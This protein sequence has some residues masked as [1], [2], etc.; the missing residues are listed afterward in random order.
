VHQPEQQAVCLRQ[1]KQAYIADLSEGTYRELLEA[2]EVC[3]VAFIH[4]GKPGDSNEPG[5]S[6]L[7]L[8][9]GEFN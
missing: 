4:P 6:D 9:A 3:Q 8:R 5:L 2:A 1:N 7:I